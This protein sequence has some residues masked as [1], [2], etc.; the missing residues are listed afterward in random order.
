[1]TRHIGGSLLSSSNSRVLSPT[2]H[3]FGILQVRA[4]SDADT[5]G[6]FWTHEQGVSLLATHSNGFS[7]R[8]LAD[9]MASGDQKRVVDQA[10]YILDCGG[11]TI[12]RDRFARI[13]GLTAC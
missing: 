2:R 11:T 5:H 13:M 8:E 3:P 4:L 7:C 1:M 12:N 9:R 10:Q 6:L